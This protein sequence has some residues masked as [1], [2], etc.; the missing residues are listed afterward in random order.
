MINTAIYR[1]PDLTKQR[2]AARH[3]II[4][5]RHAD[6]M[7][8]DRQRHFARHALPPGKGTTRQFDRM[9]INPEADATSAAALAK[10]HGRVT[11]Q[12]QS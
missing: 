12:R 5:A 4:S 3:S 1:L 2:Y 10:A 7:G 6:D 8:G 9:K 11:R